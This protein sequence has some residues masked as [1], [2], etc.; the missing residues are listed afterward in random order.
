[1]KQRATFTNWDFGPV[2]NM[3]EG[4]SYPILFI[5]TAPSIITTSPVNCSKP[6]II[7]KTSSPVGDW[8]LHF[9]LSAYSDS[10]GT[11]LIATV[12]S[13]T[14][15]ELWEYSTDNGLRWYAF[16]TGGLPPAKYGALV[17]ARLEVGPR[18]QVYIKA[19]VG[20]EDA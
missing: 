18:T 5:C 9:K 14:N 2:W 20:A 11:S 1:M 3:T 7:L 4:E 12:D 16:S 15:P 8:Y 17:R 19:S 13:S 6:L 10:G